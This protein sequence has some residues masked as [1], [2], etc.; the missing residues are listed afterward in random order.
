MA[1]AYCTGQLLCCMILR[2]C[3]RQRL[4]NLRGHASCCDET[5]RDYAWQKIRTRYAALALWQCRQG[6]PVGQPIGFSIRSL[7][8]P[9]IKVSGCGSSDGD[10]LTAGQSLQ[11]LI[12]QKGPGTWFDMQSSKVKNYQSRHRPCMMLLYLLIDAE[13]VC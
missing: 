1:P 2:S 5:G 6:Y 8:N 11:I 9:N 12:S 13:K 10:T 3:C 4:L 7:L